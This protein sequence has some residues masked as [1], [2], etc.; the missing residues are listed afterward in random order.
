[1]RLVLAIIAGFA[2]L[3]C[4]GGGEV[5]EPLA[6]SPA[7]GP[8]VGPEAA[9]SVD[10]S[11]LG[12]LRLELGDARRDAILADPSTSAEVAAIVRDGLLTFSEYESSVL[13]MAACV[14]DAGG[15]FYRE[16]QPKLTWRG[17]YIYSTGFPEAVPGAQAAVNGCVERYVGVLDLLWKE[18]TNPTRQEEESAMNALAKCLQEFGLDDIIPDGRRRED[19]EMLGPKLNADDRALY[20]SCAQR[21]GEEYALP[22]FGPTY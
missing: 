7:N 1:M 12:S 20:M 6:P 21:I 15:V 5:L 3:S 17:L 13:A 18:V 11:Q 22:Y 9:S 10:R 14:R 2:V 16:N 8:S 19:F 4:S